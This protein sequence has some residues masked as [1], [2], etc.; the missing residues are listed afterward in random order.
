LLEIERSELPN[1]VVIEKRS[2]DINE[3][4]PIGVSLTGASR[5]GALLISG[6]AEESHYTNPHND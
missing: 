4:V 1:L 2:A 6:V 5:S 3:L